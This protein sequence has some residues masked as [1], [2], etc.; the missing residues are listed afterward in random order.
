MS[1]K[2]DIYDSKFRNSNF[3]FYEEEGNKGIWLRNVKNPKFKYKPGKISHFFDN[4]EYYSVTIIKD[5]FSNREVKYYYNN[6]V[7]ITEEFKNNE[8]IRIHYEDGFKKIFH[9][10][11]GNVSWEGTY[12]NNKRNGLCTTYYEDG[13][14]ESIKNYKDDLMHG[15]FKEFHKN[16]ILNTIGKYWRGRRMDTIKWYDQDGI[17][18]G[19]EITKLD[20]INNSS[21][22][23]MYHFYLSGKLH[24]RIEIQNEIRNGKCEFFYESGQL[25]QICYY[26]N[27]VLNGTAYLFYESGEISM[28]LNTV[29]NKLHGDINYY[30]P[31]EKLIKIEKYNQGVLMDS[32]IKVD[33]PWQYE[34]T[35]N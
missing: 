13:T 3:S 31:N 9:S 8:S 27:D 29:N 12:K 19:K 26:E 35:T 5:S 18:L 25:N 28:E 34:K 16:K 15:G 33:I 20:T 22:G 23:I 10:N 7:S 32:I 21:T 17:L 14:I 2:D 30:N 11:K 1:C 24:K 6:K 4:G